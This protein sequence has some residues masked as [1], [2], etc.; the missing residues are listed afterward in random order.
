VKWH[1][2]VSFTVVYMSLKQPKG[3]QQTG[4]KSSL[5]QYKEP[6][7]VTFHGQIIAD[8][9]LWCPQSHGQICYL[10]PRSV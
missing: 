1:K 3:T 6:K 8:R 4:H 7:K 5:F 9:H 10:C 2:K